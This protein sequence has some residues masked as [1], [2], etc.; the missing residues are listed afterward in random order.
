MALCPV[1]VPPAL[2]EADSSTY[3]PENPR[4]APPLRGRGGPTPPCRARGQGP[5]PQMHPNLGACAAILSCSSAQRTVPPP[6][7]CQAGAAILSS[8]LSQRC[9][10][11]PCPPAALPRSCHRQ[12]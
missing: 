3:Y 4:R 7:R 9:G 1:A 8:M 6:Q 12:P 2:G 11:G 10:Y 5:P